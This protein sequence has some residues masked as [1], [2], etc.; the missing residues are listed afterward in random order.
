MKFIITSAYALC[1]LFVFA[2]SDQERIKEV[3]KNS[4]YMEFLG[5]GYFSGNYERS[6]KENHRVSIGFGWNHH[7]TYL[8]SEEAFEMGVEGDHE[9]SPYLSFYSQYSHL[10]GKNRSKLEI[11]FGSILTFFDLG[12]FEFANRLY[13][14]E[15]YVSIYPIIGYRFEAYKGFIFMFTFNP[16]IQIPQGYIWPI[17]GISVGYRF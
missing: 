9:V 4:V 2:Q 1:F 7:E 15:S 11:G 12:R 6:F 3:K 14:T 16:I 13:E 10:F 5:R 17:P 8:T